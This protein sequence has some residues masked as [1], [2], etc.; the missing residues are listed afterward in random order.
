MVMPP[1]I[2]PFVPPDIE[3]GRDPEKDR[4]FWAWVA[5]TYTPRQVEIIQS[6]DYDFS[7]IW[8]HYV[9]RIYGTQW[10]VGYRATGLEDP[11]AYGVT[12]ADWQRLTGLIR[13]EA[14][15]QGLLQG[16]I[17]QERISQS[18]AAD[19]WDE[20]RGQIIRASRAAASAQFRTEYALYATGQK[21]FPEDRARRLARALAAE[22]EE[23]WARTRREIA[24]LGGMSPAAWARSE[25]RRR[26]ERELAGFREI[27][28]GPGLE[29][30]RAG[31]AE[32][33]PRTERWR[34]WFRSKYP[35]MVE[36]FEAK[37]PERE[38]VEKT[39]AEY[40]KKRKPEFREEWYGLSPWE[41]GERPGVYA[42]R[43]QT[44]GF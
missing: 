23:E 18:Q 39:W 11:E 31:L 7:S 17:D 34:D 8:E 25:E 37:V 30:M 26:R 14:R 36:Q 35:R 40:L 38:R 22:K 9:T 28:Y 29:E 33:M 6:E 41:R 5:R 19:I 42:P 15:L 10:D 27:G 1:R 44:V 24:E 20:L 3:V 13:D 4:S 43:I 32:E 12:G 16:W 2:K 21:E